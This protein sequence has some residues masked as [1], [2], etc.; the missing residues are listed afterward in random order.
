MALPNPPKAAGVAAGV[1]DPAVLAVPAEP[2]ANG[3]GVGAA[4]VLVAGVVDGAALAEAAPPNVTGAAGVD[5][6]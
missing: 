6:N 3:A 2:N 5:P 4:A 1:V